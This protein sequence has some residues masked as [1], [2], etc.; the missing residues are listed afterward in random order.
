[1]S[2]IQNAKISSASLGF[3]DHA[4][5][6]CYLSLELGASS[7]IGFGGYALDSYQNDSKQRKDVSG[8]GL[9]FI[10]AI[11]ETVGVEKWEDLKGKY[12]AVELENEW[13]GPVVGIR[14]ILDENKWFRPKE[15]FEENYG[16]V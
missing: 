3:E 12:I 9:E 16:T 7:V 15:W 11:L 8:C 6:T 13:S 10:R 4:I 5:F 2:K 1:M 14:N